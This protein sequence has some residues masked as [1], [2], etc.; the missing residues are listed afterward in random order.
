MVCVGQSEHPRRIEWELQSGA[1]LAAIDF[2]GPLLYLTLT[3][4]KT[5]EGSRTG[6][7]C[8][9]C[10]LRSKI[11]FWDFQKV[12]SPIPRHQS[13]CLI[14]QMWRCNFP[15]AG[16][17]AEFYQVHCHRR[18]VIGCRHSLRMF[19]KFWSIRPRLKST[20]N[21]SPDWHRGSRLHFEW[22]VSGLTVVSFW[23]APVVTLCVGI[24]ALELRSGYPAP[25]GNRTSALGAG[26][27]S[28]NRCL[29]GRPRPS[30]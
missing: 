4:E 8:H 25:A 6:S 29:A 3:Q 12:G 1:S 18:R 20:K 2:E 22:K 21:W 24:P 7:F 11:G 10:F 5:D 9:P 14:T 26:R 15:V 17:W 23:T 30:C 27:L 19:L 28:P 16:F 13:K